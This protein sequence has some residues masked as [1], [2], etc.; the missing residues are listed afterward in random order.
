MNAPAIIGDTLPGMIQRAA[1]ALAASSDAAGVLEVEEMSDAIRAMGR[2]A[3]RMAKAQAAHDE[4]IRAAHKAQGDAL[5][6][7]AAASKRYYEMTKAAQDAGEIPTRGGDRRSDDFKLSGQKFENPEKHYAVAHF[8]KTVAEAE[9]QDP[10]IVRRTIDDALDEGRAP[11]LAD[12]KQATMREKLIERASQEEQAWLD[13]RD[14]RALRKLWN[15]S[16]SNA[17][18]MFRDYIGG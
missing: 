14:F 5:D 18:R 13:K 4:V 8:G 1:Q 15:A 12:I 2:E 17:Q 11:K 9:E 7:K 10:G 6:I 16:T 3:E